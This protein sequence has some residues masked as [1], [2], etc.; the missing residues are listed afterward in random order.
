MHHIT[1]VKFS[2][3]ALEQA[4]EKITYVLCFFLVIIDDCIGVGIWR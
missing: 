4:A 2:K 3:H 1:S